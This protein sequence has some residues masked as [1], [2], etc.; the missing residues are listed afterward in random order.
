[1]SILER[2]REAISR[3]KQE[4]SVLPSGSST[5]LPKYELNEKNEL[6]PS[7]DGSLHAREYELNEK[8][9][10]SPAAI[11]T[12][13]AWDAA[14]AAVALAEC[15]A[16]VNDTIAA[17]GLTAAQRSVIEVMR[18]VVRVHADQRD[19]LLWD[20]IDFLREKVAEW[21]TLNSAAQKPSPALFRAVPRCADW[22]AKG[23][24]PDLLDLVKELF[25]PEGV[26]PKVGDWRSARPGDPL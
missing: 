8:N 24:E 13:P 5:T 2:A 23:D 4:R 21:K 15:E 1:M 18:G 20:D 10:L 16:A 22:W 25:P 17:A 12:G 6:S 3:G 7:K 14:C 19:P 26:A 11:S 9:E